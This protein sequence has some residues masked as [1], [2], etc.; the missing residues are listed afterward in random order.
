MTALV[1]RSE[2]SLASL[3]TSKPFYYNRLP[4]T[5]AELDPNAHDYRQQIRFGHEL[6]MVCGATSSA[7]FASGVRN[8]WKHA[9]GL[10]QIIATVTAIAIAVPID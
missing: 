7:R 3:R 4:A 9:G 2:A 8:S 1:R 5:V 6:R 10:V